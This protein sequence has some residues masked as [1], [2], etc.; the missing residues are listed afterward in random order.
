MIW[1]LQNKQD[2]FGCPMDWIWPGD[3]FSP[4]AIEGN[5]ALHITQRAHKMAPARRRLELGAAIAFFGSGKGVLLQSVSL[6]LEILN[7]VFQGKSHAMF[8]IHIMPNILPT[9]GYFR[10]PEES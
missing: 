5:K 2:V 6:S 4:F 9:G 8:N 3:G 1:A 10:C 7:R